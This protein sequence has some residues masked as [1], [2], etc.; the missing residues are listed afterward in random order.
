MMSTLA[1]SNTTKPSNKT[2]KTSTS[3]KTI[4]AKGEQHPEDWGTEKK[5]TVKD[6]LDVKKESKQQKKNE[7]N[8]TLLA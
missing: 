6:K 2:S 1:D 4:I 8:T 7:T 3:K 5:E